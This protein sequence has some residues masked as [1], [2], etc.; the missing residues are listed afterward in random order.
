MLTSSNYLTAQWKSQW[1][2]CSTIQFS[3]TF[4]QLIQQQKYKKC[5]PFN[6][7]VTSESR[8]VA[9][10]K[11]RRSEVIAFCCSDTIRSSSL[12][13]RTSC[14][15]ANSSM[16]G[17]GIVGAGAGGIMVSLWPFSNSRNI[18]CVQRQFNEINSKI[19]NQ[20]MPVAQPKGGLGVEIALGCGKKIFQQVSMYS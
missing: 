5:S 15:I 13:S 16:T 4:Y 18:E 19:I 20:C 12:L 8:A 7:P 3:N 1:F 9:P 11:S 6:L 10:A 2:L 14:P 17:C